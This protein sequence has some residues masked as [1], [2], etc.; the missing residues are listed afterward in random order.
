MAI[1]NLEKGYA[2]TLNS[3]PRGKNIKIPIVN[4]CNVPYRHIVVDLP[5]S[6]KCLIVQSHEFCNKI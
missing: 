2:Y 5:A 6:T 3:M 1:L 4:S